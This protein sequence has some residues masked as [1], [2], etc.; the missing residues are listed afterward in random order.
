VLRVDRQ[1]SDLLAGSDQQPLRQRRRPQPLW[2]LALPALPA[3]PLLQPQASASLEQPEQAS[4]GTS[5][6]TVRQTLTWICLVTH[7]GT[8]TV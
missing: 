1:V 4:Q 3:L 6:Q 5:S 2:P 7:F 8:H